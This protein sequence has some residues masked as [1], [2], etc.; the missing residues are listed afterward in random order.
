[1]GVKAI[2]DTCPVFFNTG[3]GKGKKGRREEGKKGREEQTKGEKE[4]KPSCPE[5]QREK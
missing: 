3:R 1:V 2:F 5:S 4:G